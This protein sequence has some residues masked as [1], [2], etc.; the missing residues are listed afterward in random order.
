MRKSDNRTNGTTSTQPA[1]RSRLRAESPS[2]LRFDIAPPA[3][4]GPAVTN[5]T[6]SRLLRTSRA[7]LMAQ[8]IGCRTTRSA[9]N[10]RPSTVRC[11]TTRS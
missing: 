5:T 2:A 10:W 4:A 7:A 9:A 8:T 6:T 11:R 3:E 1:C